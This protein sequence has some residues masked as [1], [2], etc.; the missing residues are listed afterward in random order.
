MPGK[1][2]RTATT[3][4]FSLSLH[5]TP[6]V[7]GGGVAVPSPSPCPFPFLV[8]TCRRRSLVGIFLVKELVLLQPDTTTVSELKLRP[9]PR[10][11]V[12]RRAEEHP[13]PRRLPL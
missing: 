9:L 11:P 5:P 2:P 7:S 1:V 6:L 8:P 10:L 12:R 3:G 13:A 4:S